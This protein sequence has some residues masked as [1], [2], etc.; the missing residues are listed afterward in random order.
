[1]IKRTYTYQKFLNQRKRN[2]LGRN[3]VSPAISNIS[4]AI[5][6]RALVKLGDDVNIL[7][8]NMNSIKKHAEAVFGASRDVGLEV[9]AEKTKYMVMSCHQNVG[10]NHNLLIANKSFKN[11]EKFKYL[12]TAVTHQNCIHEEIKSR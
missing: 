4:G 8:E 7:D 5:S 11:V 9:N 2:A 6:K 10:Q 1:V 12:G 3:R